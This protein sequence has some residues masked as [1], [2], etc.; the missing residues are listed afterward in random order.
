MR[1]GT[2]WF[3]EPCFMGETKQTVNLPHWVDSAREGEDWPGQARVVRDHEAGMQGTFF[4]SLGP[5]CNSQIE[6]RCTQLSTRRHSCSAPAISDEDGRSINLLLPGVHIRRNKYCT[7]SRLSGIFPDE[8]ERAPPNS[9]PP[10]RRY[11][12][13]RS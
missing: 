5:F 7:F 13:Q 11:P 8:Y 10:T 4:N 3:D 9:W 1:A 2:D 12:G 6:F